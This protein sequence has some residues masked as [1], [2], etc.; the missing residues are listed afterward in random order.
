MVCGSRKVSV[1]EMWKR[2]QINED[3]RKMHR[4]E[5]PVKKFGKMRKA[6][7]GRS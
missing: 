7:F 3:A 4:T 1:H 2:K 6:T 5:I